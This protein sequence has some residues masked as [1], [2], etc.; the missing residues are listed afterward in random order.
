MITREQWNR[1][2]KGSIVRYHNGSRWI[3]RTVLSGPA[4]PGYVVKKGK[5]GSITFVKIKDSYI[6][7]PTTTYTY[8][9]LKNKIEFTGMRIKPRQPTAAEQRNLRQMYGANAM[10]LV[11]ERMD[12]R[13]ACHKRISHE[14]GE[15]VCEHDGDYS[16]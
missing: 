16:P 13:E 6:H 9:D 5:T 3:L 10:Q 4:D 14:Y 1:L 8:T 15:G 12:W 7:N 2:G 11:Q